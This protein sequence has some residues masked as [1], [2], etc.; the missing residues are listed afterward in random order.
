MDRT[1]LSAWRKRRSLRGSGVPPALIHL[2]Q[3]S[4]NFSG[5]DDVEATGEPLPLLA[6]TIIWSGQAFWELLLRPGM[7]AW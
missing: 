1:G 2:I 7:F 5:D 6:G 4:S 3:R